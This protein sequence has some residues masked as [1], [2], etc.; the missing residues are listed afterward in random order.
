[1]HQQVRMKALYDTMK[2]LNQG[3]ITFNQGKN[4]GI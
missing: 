1:M 3:K 2:E 4:Q